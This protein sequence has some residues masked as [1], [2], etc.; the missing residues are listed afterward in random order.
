MDNYYGHILF[1]PRLLVHVVVFLVIF[2]FFRFVFTLFI[3]VI[4]ISQ[5]GRG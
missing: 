4:I 1:Y 3:S 5:V 2:T